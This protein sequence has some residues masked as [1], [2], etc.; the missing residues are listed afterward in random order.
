MNLAVLMNLAALLFPLIINRFEQVTGGEASLTHFVIA[1]AV[2]M[3]LWPILNSIMVI[4]FATVINHKAVARFCSHPFWQ[5]FNKLGLVIFLV[6]W[7]II[8]L[9]FTSYEQGAPYGYTFEAYIMY[10]FVIMWSILS[11]IAIHVLFET[12][13]STLL[14]MLINTRKSTKTWQC[15]FP[16]HDCS[17]FESPLQSQVKS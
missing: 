2:L 12:P 9:G 4:Y 17:K 16:V 10:G 6:H 13:M 14:M 3:V 7:E 1:N 11:A 15:T 8:V 5:V